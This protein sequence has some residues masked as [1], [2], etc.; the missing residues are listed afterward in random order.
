MA[1]LAKSLGV[2]EHELALEPDSRSTFENAARSAEWLRAHGE[3]ELI[4]VSCD[5]HL[6]RATAHFRGRGL[7]VWPVPSLRA[8]SAGN[9]VLVTVKELAAL[10]RRPWLIARL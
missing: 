9:R 6:A 2:Q 4:L 5:F 10:L 8:L 7:K 1:R 3:T